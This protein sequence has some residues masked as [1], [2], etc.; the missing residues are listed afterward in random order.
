V[1]NHAER[2]NAHVM[3][4]ST[5]RRPARQPGEELGGIFDLLS[6]FYPHGR[7]RNVTRPQAGRVLQ[8]AI[9]IVTS[10]SHRLID[11]TWVTPETR[12]LLGS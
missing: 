7:S 5:T 11:T 6:D 2:L 4:I 1:E 9:F 8:R 10:T 3:G 12:E